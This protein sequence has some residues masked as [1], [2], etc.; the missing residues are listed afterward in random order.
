MSKLCTSDRKAKAINH[1][2]LTSNLVKLLDCILTANQRTLSD[3]TIDL[4]N[5][6][7]DLSPP[8][9][10]VQI[11]SRSRGNQVQSFLAEESDEEDEVP[12]EEKE[13]KSSKIT[14]LQICQSSIS[15]IVEFLCQLSRFKSTGIVM[16]RSNT[17]DLLMNLIFSADT[18]EHPMCVGGKLVASRIVKTLAS[19]GL[20]NVSEL[21]NYLDNRQLAKL[22]EYLEAE[23]GFKHT[24][25]RNT[26]ATSSSSLVRPK[27]SG[28]DIIGTRAEIIVHTLSA[29]RS[30]LHH[31][32]SHKLYTEFKDASGYEIFLDAADWLSKVDEK[33]L[34]SCVE[35]FDGSIQGDQ[36]LKIQFLSEL[37][38]TVAEF[39][40]SGPEALSLPKEKL[41]VI[42]F[43]PSNRTQDMV[44]I[45][46]GLDSLRVR[47][48]DAFRVLMKLFSMIQLEGFKIEALNRIL[49]TFSSHPDNYWILY[50]LDVTK[51]LIKSLPYFS[52]QVRGM[53]MKI[54]E[55]VAIVV[56]AVP[57]Q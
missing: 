32:Q 57:F 31:S 56:Q 54:V 19:R 10:S 50:P 9:K 33:S 48:L 37:L 16:I 1:S 6:E 36:N 15:T 35:G 20:D 4:D 52:E 45:D 38:K 28:K 11:L 34:Q 53:V 55:S 22:M 23:I 13:K 18:D 25:S 44:G 26:F 14:H 2:K 46:E 5:K 17:L 47:N 3:L 43:D 49:M 12:A 27:F 7:K 21:S 24:S 8:Q 40:F 30:L 41:E 29:T 39:V 42:A 51:T